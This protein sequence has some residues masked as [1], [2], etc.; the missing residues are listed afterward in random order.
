MR[1]AQ[2]Q[3]HENVDAF[4]CAFGYVYQADSG[5]DARSPDCPK[6]PLSDRTPPTSVSCGEG[7]DRRQRLLG[8]DGHAIHRPDRQGFIRRAA[9]EESSRC[10][11]EG[12]ALLES[13]DSGQELEN[14]QEQF[15]RWTFRGSQRQGLQSYGH[16][17]PGGTSEVP[18]S[19][20]LVTSAAP[21]SQPC[22][23]HLPRPTAP[24]LDGTGDR[25]RSSS[26]KVQAED[27]RLAEGLFRQGDF[28]QCMGS[29]ATDDFARRST[30]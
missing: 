12:R 16:K 9:R 2:K 3:V 4:C 28:D 17:V 30:R 25:H 21:G 19:E 27:K 26:N 18:S 24:R 1:R 14:H 11:P 13:S 29:E 20:S 23:V 22:R 7:D 8:E 10:T 6:F 15:F 5:G